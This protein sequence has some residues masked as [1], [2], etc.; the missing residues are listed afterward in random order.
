MRPSRVWPS[1]QR[2]RSSLWAGTGKAFVSLTRCPIATV[3]IRWR[4]LDYIEDEV[5]LLHLSKIAENNYCLLH[6]LI[7][8]RIFDTLIL[9]MEPPIRVINDDLCFLCLCNTMEDSMGRKTASGIIISKGGCSITF[10]EQKFHDRSIRYCN[11]LGCCASRYAVQSTQ[12]GEDNKNF[13]RSSSSKSSSSVAFREPRLKQRLDEEDAA[14]SSNRQAN[15]NRRKYTDSDRRFGKKEKS[16]SVA[17]RPTVEPAKV[18]RLSENASQEVRSKLSSRA[19]KEAARQPKSHFK[20]NSNTSGNNPMALTHIE[21]DVSSRSEDYGLNDLRQ[22]DASD[23]SLSNFTSADFADGMG[24]NDIRRRSFGSRSLSSRG[25]SI[26][27]SVTA[28]SSVS[29]SINCLPHNLASNQ[30]PR[31]SRSQSTSTGV[32]SVRTRQA[33]SG[34]PRTRPLGQVDEFNLLLDHRSSSRSSRDAMS[35]FDDFS[36]DND[37]YPHLNR[38]IAEVL[39]ELERIEHEG[40]TFEEQLSFLENRLFFDGLIN[41]QY[42]DMRMDIDSMTYE[43]LL[44]LGEEMGT[45]ST[46]LTEEAVSK[47]LNRSNYVP[48]SPISGFSRSNEGDA[49]CSIC[50][51]EWVAEDEIGSLVCEHF[52]HIQCI[53]QWLRLKNWCPICKASVT[54][55]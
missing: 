27:S 25:K 45:V 16:K 39:L 20:D 46:A 32:V 55:P 41:D 30:N 53:E 26:Y 14:E 40:L 15:G 6:V 21:R 4:E 42:S 1:T 13:I 38:S 23:L 24:E 5:V 10:R 12:V 54:P 52:Y 11:R 51:E 7:E 35:L 37:G 44:A 50:Q 31:R 28:T 9:A 48:A 18:Q 19:S 33:S 17:F 2:L 34:T 47:C 43:E 49:K 3:P 36:E 8:K 22:A 29:S